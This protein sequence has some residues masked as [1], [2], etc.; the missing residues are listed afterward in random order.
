MDVWE[1][2]VKARDDGWQQTTVGDAG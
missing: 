2:R 1:Y